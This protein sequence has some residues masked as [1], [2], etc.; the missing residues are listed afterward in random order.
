MAL[1]DF[2]QSI[3]IHGL[4][5][6]TPWLLLLPTDP[7]PNRIFNDLSPLSGC[8]LLTAMFFPQRV[9]VLAAQGVRSGPGHQLLG[10]CLTGG[11]RKTVMHVVRLI[12]VDMQQFSERFPAR[13]ADGGEE[14]EE[15]V[16]EKRTGMPAI[17]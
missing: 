14:G 1:H 13:L 5:V 16:Q 9:Q 6:F 2:I 17:V 8:N 3:P 15:V 10:K 4:T 12:P 11:T 7:A